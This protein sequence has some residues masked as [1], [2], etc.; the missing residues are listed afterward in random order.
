[1][2]EVLNWETFYRKV[3]F[4]THEISIAKLDIFEPDPNQQIWILQGS[5]GRTSHAIGV[6]GKYV[7]D[8]NAT[9]A[10]ML[11][12]KTLDWCCN[13]KEGF[14]QIHMYVRFRK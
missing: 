2:K 4:L 5:D 9:N 1:M 14:N 13:C 12:Q 6:F 7:F 8:S 3:D 11:T 10:L